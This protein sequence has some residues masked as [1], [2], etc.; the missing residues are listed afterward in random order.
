MPLA[1]ALTTPSAIPLEVDA[2]TLQ[3]VR[4]LKPDAVR[5]ILIQRGNR[6]APLGDFFDVSGSAADDTLVWQGDL[7]RVKW[8]GARHSGGRVLV[9][10]NCG[11]HLGSEMTGGEIEVRGN[12]ADWAGAELHGGRIRIRGNAGHLVGSAYRG[13]RRGMTGGEIII[14][15]HVG[16][17]IGH[18]MRRGLIAIAGAAGDFLGVSMIA[19][20]ILTFGEVG[21]RHGAGMKRGTI[22]L[23]GARDPELLPTFREACE[24]QPVFLNL[25]AA[26]L[27]SLGFEPA[28]M[29]RNRRVRRYCGDLLELGKGEIFAAA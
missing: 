21:I 16:N 24:C 7:S 5:G 9:E 2:V 26:R 12:V 8:I 1:I 15:G 4:D 13:A 20:S 19:G 23:L 25:V 10:G 29:L 27:E 17:E 22:G 3:A 28:G 18:A 11:M 6:Q 14:D